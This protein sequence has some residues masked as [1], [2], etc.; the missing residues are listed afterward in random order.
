MH[1]Y[2]M[3]ATVIENSK[4]K[5][6]S[7]NEGKSKCRPIAGGIN[8]VWFQT[9]PTVLG[10]RNVATSETRETNSSMWL[11][12]PNMDIQEWYM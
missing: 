7:E 6:M 1:C 10:S 9:W 2:K 11:R 4:S 12:R 8:K 5:I 3:E